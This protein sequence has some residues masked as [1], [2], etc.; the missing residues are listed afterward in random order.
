MMMMIKI[1]FSNGVIVRRAQFSGEFYGGRSWGRSEG[2]SS[3][4]GEGAGA[5]R[6]GVNAY[7]NHLSSGPQGASSS[8]SSDDGRRGTGE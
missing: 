8:S 7:S 3:R 6:A 5:P 2:L 1:S 4:W